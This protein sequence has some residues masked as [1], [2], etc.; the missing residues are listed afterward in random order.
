VEV[1]A[2]EIGLEVR[3]NDDVVGTDFVEW[4]KLH[5]VRSALGAATTLLFVWALAGAG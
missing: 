1:R 5:C 4:G 2:Q 3:R